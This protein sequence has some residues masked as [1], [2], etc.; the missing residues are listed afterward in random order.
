LS[1]DPYGKDSVQL[2]EE[3]L[4]EYGIELKKGK[5][6]VPSKVNNGG[7]PLANMSTR[8]AI[9]WLATRTGVSS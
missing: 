6:L 7:F 2:I 4:K 3:L 9:E 8:Q 1:V 5:G